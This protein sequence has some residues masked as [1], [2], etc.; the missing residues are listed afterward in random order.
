MSYLPSFFKYSY[1]GGE[2]SGVNG[3]WIIEWKPILSLVILKFNKGTREAYHSHAFNALTWFIK[4]HVSEH[5]IDGRTIEWFPSLWPKYT[6]KTCFH[7]VEAHED[8]YAFCIRGPW[9]NTWN[10][11][12]ENNKEY[13][14]LTYG[15]Q[16]VD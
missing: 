16:I 11:Y 3:F 7:K 5:H 2:K 1:D 14:K 6:P 12:R 8:T 13:V 15:R 4:G 9:D 10:E